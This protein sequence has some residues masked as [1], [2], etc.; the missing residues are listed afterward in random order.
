VDALDPRAQAVTLLTLH[1]AKGLEFPVVVPRGCED[2]LLPLRFPGRGGVTDDDIA[3]E[4]R[5]SFR[6]SDPS[7]GTAWFV[8]HARKRHVRGTERERC[9]PTRFLDAID[10]R[11]FEHPWRIGAGR[12]DGTTN[13]ACSDQQG[14][15]SSVGFPTERHQPRERPPFGHGDR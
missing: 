5:R 4:R 14:G 2:G 12:T 8:S 15:P 1:A 3:E 7:A 10:P 6:R 9:D 11:L 13:C